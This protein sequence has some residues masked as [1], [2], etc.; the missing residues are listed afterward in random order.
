[1]Y[2]GF[3]DDKNQVLEKAFSFAFKWDIFFRFNLQTCKKARM[4]DGAVDADWELANLVQTSLLISKNL[5][6]LLFMLTNRP[7]FHD[8]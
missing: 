5:F 1:M 4:W 7:S 6:L 2:R 3:H 8:R